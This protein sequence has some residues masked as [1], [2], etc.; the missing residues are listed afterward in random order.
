MIIALSIF[1][2]DG[3]VTLYHNVPIVFGEVQEIGK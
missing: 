1:K 2:W 3:Y